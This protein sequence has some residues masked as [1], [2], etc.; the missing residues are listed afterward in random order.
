MT[1][2]EF[3]LGTYEGALK[4]QPALLVTASKRLYD[5]IYKEGAAPPSTDKRLA[6]EL[7]IG[8]SR[9]AEGE[10]DLRWIDARQQIADCRTEHASRKFEDVL[11][12]V[13]NKGQWRI[14]A[15]QTMLET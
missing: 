4:K 15:E 7:A 6:I 14:T 1:T 3:S 10:A 11:R 5:A 13:I 8:R 12:Q 9:A 2:A